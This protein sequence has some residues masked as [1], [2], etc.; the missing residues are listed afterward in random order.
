MKKVCCPTTT[1]ADAGCCGLTF[2]QSEVR[3]GVMTIGRSTDSFFFLLFFIFF[4]FFTWLWRINCASFCFAAQVIP[5]QWAPLHAKTT[6][7]TRASL[8]RG[9]LSHPFPS[10]TLSNLPTEA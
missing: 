2:V 3:L 1:N 8:G 5:S 10:S 6:S 9:H 7:S 4:S